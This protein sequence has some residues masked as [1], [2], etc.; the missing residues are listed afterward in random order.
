MNFASMNRIFA[1]F[2]GLTLVFSGCKSGNKKELPPTE[3]APGEVFVVCHES[4]KEETEVRFKTG[5]KNFSPVLLMAEQAEKR[6][7]E[8]TF[9]FWFGRP[10]SFEGM[11][12]QSPLI[13]VMEIG[14][15]TAGNYSDELRALKPQS[16][17]NGRGFELHLY[18]NVWA[19]K[20]TVI[21][22]VTESMVE[23][24]QSFTEAITPI[25][26]AEETA[27]GLPGNLAP[28]AYCDSVA[29]LI[30]GNFGYSFA[31]PPQFKLQFSNR[32]VVWLWQETPRFYRHL[33]VNTFSDSIIIDNP[34]KAVANRNAFTTK[35]V[36]NTEGTRVVV[37]ESALFPLIWENNVKLGKHTVNI[38]RG[39]YTEEGTFRR[40]PFVRYFFHDKA[41][42]RIIAM[43]GFLHAP[44]MAKLPFYRSF[45]LIAASMN[46]P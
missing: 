5:Y 42:N 44:D 12:K 9:N 31:F 27:Q 16:I 6:A 11:E 3:G 10:E 29:K 25:L 45:D 15:K 43:D 8:P 33:F 34:Q 18:K 38:L 4:L 2:V 1:I 32:E 35:Y 17:S 28:T 39:W 46:L 26:L 22:C 14:G 40:G 7:F 24:F 21:R 23:D 19:K 36:K 30:R 41:N 37:S 20:Q 13:L